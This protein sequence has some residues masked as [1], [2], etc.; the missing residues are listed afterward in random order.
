MIVTVLVKKF[1]SPPN[2]DSDIDEGFEVRERFEEYGVEVAVTILLFEVELF[3]ESM[4]IVDDETM[5][6]EDIN[7]DNI[8]ETR[9]DGC[10]DMSMS[11]DND[12][13][14]SME[15]IVSAEFAAVD[16]QQ[17]I[18]PVTLKNSL[19]KFIVWSK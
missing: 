18:Q 17:Q 19:K 13:D 16:N 9:S 8:S 4:V 5:Q 7:L 1:V 14:E 3:V 10:S 6:E 15:S 2:A 12:E 11:S